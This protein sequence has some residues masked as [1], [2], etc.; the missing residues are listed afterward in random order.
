MM[1]LTIPSAKTPTVQQGQEGASVRMNVPI[2]HVKYISPEMRHAADQ[3]TFP[4]LELPS[5][6]VIPKGI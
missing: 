4:D 2:I 6:T 3:Q 5:R 1:M